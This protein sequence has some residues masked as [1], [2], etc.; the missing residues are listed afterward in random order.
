MQYQNYQ[1]QDA[2]AIQRK[3]FVRLEANVIHD[4]N[5]TIDSESFDEN[6]TLNHYPTC[7]VLIL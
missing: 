6:P 1:H 7:H 3:Q 4:E 5:L 2:Y